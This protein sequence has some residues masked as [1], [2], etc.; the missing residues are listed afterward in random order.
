MTPHKRFK[1]TDE[2]WRNREKWDEYLQA[3]ADMFEHT[4]T[5]SAPWHIVATN[6]KNS[7]RIA[8]LEHILERLKASK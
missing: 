8:V 7:A 2:D 1:I 3:A 6:D 4:S 5:N